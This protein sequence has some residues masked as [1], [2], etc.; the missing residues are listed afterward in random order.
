MTALSREVLASLPLWV[1][2]PGYD[3][4]AIE[5]GSIHI[6]LGAFH[7][8]HQ[9]VYTDTVLKSDP[10][11]GI[12]GVSLK[13]PRVAQSLAQQ[14]GLYAV[15]E[16]GASGTSARVIGAVREA[17]FLGV[18]AASLIERFSDP[19]VHVVSLTVTEKGYCHD[20]ATGRLDRTHPDIAHDLAH[21]RAPVSAIGV[22]VAGL[23]ARRRSGGGPVNVVC[24]DNLPHNGRTL[25]T[26]VNAFAGEADPDLA[27]WIGTHVAFPCTMVDRIVPA[28]TDA[29]LT[30]AA[31]LLGVADAVPVAT[32]PFSDW[33][34]ENRF[35][36]PR[37]AW[38]EAGARIVADVAPFESMKLR[39]LNGSHSTLAYLGYLLGHEY[40][41]Q[42]A[43]DPLLG[44]LVERML[45]LEVVPTLEVPKD[46]D[47]SAYCA[48]LL[49][50]FRNPALPH[51]T[52]QIAMDGSQK[53]PQ[54]V[55]ATVRDRLAAGGSIEHLALAI[56]GWIR[57]A[58]GTDE[59]GYSISVADPQAHRFAAI[60]AQ[61]RGNASQLADGFLGLAA[62]FG[63]DLSRDPAFRSAVARDVGAM[64]RDGVRRTIAVFV[65]QARA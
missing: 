2:R 21:R 46:V 6:G 18:G 23:D 62:V 53:L 54:R 61:A 33:V 41:W 65:A 8:A 43:S 13:T 38:E 52:Q 42:A 9:A 40:L 63:E 15:L 10:R 39:L 51:R 47:V 48:D 7:R 55:L 60:A 25:E 28:T 45:A 20:P 26:L 5:T 49:A 24:C 44:T 30:E 59:Q 58:S 27:S 31:H 11:W 17:R 34:I 1:A 14:D 56:A 64:M 12:C 16:K 37:P 19:G 50:R 29:D 57:Y 3:L 32:E 36:A 35:I 22:L 4:A